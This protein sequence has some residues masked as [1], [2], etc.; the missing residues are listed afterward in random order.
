MPRLGR[1]AYACWRNSTTI[2]VRRVKSS[3]AS[4][5]FEQYRR[6][7][8]G[9]DRAWCS[10]LAEILVHACKAFDIPARYIVMGHIVCP[11]KT[12]AESDYSAMLTTGHT[13][14]EIFDPGNGL[15]YWMDPSYRVLGLYLGDEGPLSML[16]LH[17]NVNRPIRFDRLK[18]DL[19]DPATGEVER[20]PLATSGI[21]ERVRNAFRPDQIFRY[22]RSPNSR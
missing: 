12:T 17:H 10:Q 3:I 1:S 13:T 8:R 18:V 9:E 14:C 4:V 22:F 16:E 21:G 19:C 20:V 11:R 15:W 7:I 2:E 6:L 5:P